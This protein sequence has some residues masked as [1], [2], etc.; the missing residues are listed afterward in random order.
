MIRKFFIYGVCVLVVVLYLTQQDK[1]EQVK[2]TTKTQVVDVKPMESIKHEVKQDV[3]TEIKTK[4]QIE[5]E[6]TQAYE[7]TLQLTSILEELEVL[8]QQRKE[9]SREELHARRHDLHSMRKA[10][11]KSLSRLLEDSQYA[12]DVY[13]QLLFEQQDETIIEEMIFAT[14]SM[15]PQN[16]EMFAMGLAY[17]SEQRHRIAAAKTLASVGTSNS[18]KTLALLAQNDENK[19]IQVQAI[20][21]LSRYQPVKNMDIDQTHDDIGNALR[22]LSSNQNNPEDIRSKALRALISRPRLKLED[23][24]YISQLAKDTNNEKIRQI[25]QNAMNTLNISSSD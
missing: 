23:K 21:S 15:Q 6:K 9:I 11:Q 22:E 14:Q 12:R 18:I 1:P 20:E 16:R 13:A 17:S 7:I 25:A 5:Y 8:Q 2:K 19:D 4:E 10:Q 24:I 3:K